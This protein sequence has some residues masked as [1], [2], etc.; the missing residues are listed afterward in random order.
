MYL[1]PLENKRKRKK[2][3]EVIGKLQPENLEV[4]CDSLRGIKEG[5]NSKKLRMSSSNAEKLNVI[6]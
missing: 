4:Q 6:D 1:I 5:A 3:G 2:L